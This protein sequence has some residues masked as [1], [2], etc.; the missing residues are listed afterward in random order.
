MRPGLD[1]IRRPHRAR[2]NR[3]ECHVRST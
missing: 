1:P 3:R 2:G